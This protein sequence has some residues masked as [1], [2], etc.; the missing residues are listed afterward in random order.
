MPNPSSGMPIADD[1]AGMPMEAPAEPFPWQSP[2]DPCDDCEALERVMATMARPSYRLADH[3]VDFL[4]A[5]DTRGARLQ[6]DY[7]KAEQ[8][9]AAHG[10]AHTI[11]VFGSARIPEPRAARRRLDAAREALDLAPDDPAARRAVALAERIADNSRYYDVAREFAALVGRL[12][13][14]PHGERIAM[15]TGGGPGLMEAANR[16]AFQVGMQSVGLNI[17][18]PYEQYPN[19]YITPDL[20]FQFHYF[21]MR[22]LHFLYRACALVAFP[23]GFGT[24]D[25]VFETLTLIQTRKIA[26]LPVVLVGRAFWSRAVDFDFLVAEGMIAGED[27]EL[28]SVV[29]TAEEI[30]ARIAAWHEAR[31]APL[32]P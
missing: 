30:Q 2:K 29:E 21:G 3:D 28:F 11:V 24:F 32:F 20:C 1:P 22:K 13:G 9:L 10:I 15:M 14:R 7:L 16:G 26:P 19:P 25:E 27:L 31:G 5:D 8:G 17:S 23:G 6:L 4:Q 12:D 18:L